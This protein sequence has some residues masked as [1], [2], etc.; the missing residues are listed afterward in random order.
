V[1]GISVERLS[2][3]RYSL[4]GELDIATAPSLDELRGEGDFT[5]GNEVVLELGDLSFI[6]SQGVRTLLGLAAALQPGGR[7]ILHAP[8]AA[9]AKVFALIRLEDIDNVELT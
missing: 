6:D 2:E 1:E 9:A 7:L 8:S 5:P 4:A 3:R